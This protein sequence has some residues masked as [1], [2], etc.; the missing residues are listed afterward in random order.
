M[1]SI[2]I[3]TAAADPIQLTTQ[4]QVLDSA[5]TSSVQYMGH[6]MTVTK[7]LTDN[8]QL[9]MADIA[10]RW[11]QTWCNSANLGVCSTYR[12]CFLTGL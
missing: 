2:L 11:V 3:A 8:V 7:F 6:H 10:V 1:R 12:T 5:L 4:Q 9:L